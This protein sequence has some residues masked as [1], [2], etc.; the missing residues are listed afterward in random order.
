MG[1]RREQVTNQSSANIVSPESRRFIQEIAD[2]CRQRT[3]NASNDEI[4]E[5][6]HTEIRRLMQDGDECAAR[7][8]KELLAREVAHG[9]VDTLLERD[10]SGPAE[11]K[12]NETDRADGSEAK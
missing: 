1:G 11:P 4:A 2:V 7:L 6:V 12:N 5:A 8:L 3:P 9:V 10:D